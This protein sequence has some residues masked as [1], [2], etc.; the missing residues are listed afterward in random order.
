[1]TTAGKAFTGRVVY[2]ERGWEIRGWR[3]T[4][5]PDAEPEYYTAGYA[6]TFGA[7]TR[8]MTLDQAKNHVA[9][10]PEVRR[11]HVEFEV[12]IPPG[13]HSLEQ[14]REWIAYEIGA[15]GSISGSNPLVDG[16]LDIVHGSLDVDVV[17]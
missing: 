5:T 14:L 7:R 8:H 10:Q 9:Q 6:H 11:A 15:N 1:M 3:P 2:S 12:V 13:E 17:R 16:A 4:E